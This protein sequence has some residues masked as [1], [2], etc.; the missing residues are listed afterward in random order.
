M[1]PG[2]VIPAVSQFLRKPFAE[3][4]IYAEALLL[5]AIFRFMILFLPFRVLLRFLGKTVAVEDNGHGSAA[6]SPEVLPV[7]RAVKAVSRRVPWDSKCLVQA[8]AGKI[9]LRRR[10]IAGIIHLGVRRDLTRS[11]AMKPHAWLTS[12]GQVLLGGGR[13][14]QYAEVSRIR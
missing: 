10:G 2:G 5:T 9:M 8:S 3:Q 6:I 4:R 14:D 13:L 12:D 1:K 11:K 7:I